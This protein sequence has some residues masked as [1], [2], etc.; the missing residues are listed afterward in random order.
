MLK[1]VTEDTF[2]LT[3]LLCH[4][5]PTCSQPPHLR[6]L[7]LTKKANRITS[8]KSATVDASSL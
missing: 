3:K 7:R 8:N 4:L 5:S 6:P 2:S 1:G